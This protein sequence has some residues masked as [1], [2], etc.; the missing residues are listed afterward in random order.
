MIKRVKYL[1]LKDK[2]NFFEFRVVNPM[3][4]LVAHNH[5][6][7]K[8]FLEK[9][10]Y[11]G[12]WVEGNDGIYKIVSDILINEEI[13]EI[14]II[15]PS[16]VNILIPN[17]K[18]KLYLDEEGLN[19]ESISSPIFITL[20]LDCRKLY[21][22]INTG[23][24][25]KVLPNSNYYFVNFVQ[26]S[27]NYELNFKIIYEG[28]LRFINEYLDIEFDYDLKRNSPFYKFTIFKGFEG[29]ITKLKI[30][31][32]DKEKL[33]IIT[34]NH[35][36]SLKRFI[37]NR[38]LSLYHPQN[39]FKAGLPWFPERWFRD[40]LLTV[41]F[42]NKEI[43]E[44]ENIMK[45]YLENLENIWNKNKIS[46]EILSADT[47]LLIISNL[48]ED[49][50]EKLKNILINFLDKWEKLFNIK[51]LPPKSTWMD[52]LTRSQAIEIDF[53]YLNTLR[54]LNLMEKFIQF[55]VMLKTNIFLKNY[56]EDEIYSPNLFLGYLLVKDVFEEYEWFNFFDL[57]IEN[58]YLKWGGFSSKSINKPD[59]QKFHTGED[60]RSYHSGDSWFWLN[61]LGAYVLG[62]FA[63]KKY[64]PYIEKIKEASFKNLFSMGVLGYMSELS[65]AEELR[66]EGS[67]IQLWS[68]SSLY[69]LL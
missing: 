27:E 11:F 5:W 7:I 24:I 49:K 22:D 8:S 68:L 34:S 41:L 61:N 40:E 53:L 28:N 65:S 15:S 39:G 12:Y 38:I 64:E 4:G 44:K 10:K 23:N 9:S 50:I 3:L 56:P 63:Y 45:F 58:F 1:E 20:L 35:P 52:T 21:S 37:L 13:E 60:S 67:P 32:E 30:I 48:E 17:N 57:I 2:E 26:E 62:T 66:Y 29:Y 42:L 51:N 19:L 47:F 18:I 16:A 69:L 59:F 55:K 31:Y 54:N 6:F 43:T 46:S 25:Y 14:E 33:K 36:D